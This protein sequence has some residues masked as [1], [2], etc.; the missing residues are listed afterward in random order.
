[1]RLELDSGVRFKFGIGESLFEL[2]DTIE[3]ILILQAEEFGMK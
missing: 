1:M 2:G 3:K